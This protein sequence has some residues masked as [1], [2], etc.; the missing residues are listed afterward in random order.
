MFRLRVTPGRAL[1]ACA[2]LLTLATP[3]WAQEGARRLGDE[4]A[5]AAEAAAQPPPAPVLTRPPELVQFVEASYPEA[6]K[7][8]QREAA[9]QLILT[10]D[11]EGKVTDAVLQGEPVGDGFDEAAIEA[12]K[13]FVFRPA[14][15]DGKPAP[16]RIGFT[17]RF[18]FVPE[19][20]PPEEEAEAEPVA[21]LVGRVRE[22]GTGA[23]VPGA[24]V[25]V[26]AQGVE[27]LADAT[28]RFTLEG[29]EPGEIELIA[30]SPDHRREVVTLTLAEGE[31]V[32]VQ[33]RLERLRRSP[34]ETIVRGEREKT[35]LTRRTLDQKE[36]R[37]VPGTFG[38]PLRVVQNLPGL[39]R[40]PYILG[41]LL[42]R[43]TSPGDSAVMIDGHEVPL[44]YHFAGG[45]SVLPPEMLGR[46]D[47]FPGNFSV[48][49]GRAIGGIIDVETRVAWPK[50]WHGS[51]EIDLFD[52]GLYMEGPLTDDTSVS[53]SVRRSYIDTIL[54]FGEAV[55][56]APLATVLPVYYDY[57]A[58]VN[59]KLGG[60]DR[61]SLLVFGS[62]DDLTV[63]GDPGDQSGANADVDA[64]LGFHRLKLSWKAH[65]TD[66]VEWDL[67]PV[68]GVDF[69]GI[70]AGRVQADGTVVEFGLRHDLRIQA[71]DDVVVRTGLD[72]LGRYVILS[73][74]VPLRTSN[75]RPHPAAGF[76]SRPT[77]ELERSILLNGAAIYG[78]VEW[79][80][81]GGPVT[82]IPGVRTDY[83]RYFDQNRFFADPRVNA[84]WALTDAFTLKG[85]AG[86]FSQ[87]PP[88]W[89]LDEEFGNPDLDLE[90]AE[91]YGLGFEWK[92]TEALTLDVEGYWSRRHDLAERSDSVTVEGGDSGFASINPARFES[93]GT[94]QSYG[95][96]MLL[97]HE[98]TD[99]LY[100]WIS[101]T[102]AFTEADSGQ[103]G[104]QGGAGEAGGGGRLNQPHNMV[105]V[106][107]Y[108][109][110][111]NWET[112]LR[113]RLGSGNADTPV[114]GDTYDGD[115][116]FYRGLQGDDNTTRQP[117][118]HQ[119]DLRIERTWIFKAWELAAFLDLQNV[120]NA[121]NP[122][123]TTYDYRFRNSA[124]VRGLPVF[125][126]FGVRG[127][128]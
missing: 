59:H 117:L 83:Y 98:V 114:V 16:I 46:I 91:H 97:K 70:D 127:S 44:L 47:F 103:E 7:A 80:P 15:M 126:S 31:E 26:P 23:P 66:A 1:L 95:I 19:A 113:F 64:A 60:K 25:G 62:H 30:T 72:L 73:A 38:D 4:E 124:K 105:V 57:Q 50:E 12:A 121:E 28:G 11:A 68:V 40:T 3:A 100:G 119:L 35:S 29:V 88:E 56:D 32:D 81:G 14:E 79:A 54:R 21:R 49:Y 86:I 118:F 58:R 101:Y 89:R 53:A 34:F 45:P 107:S 13:Q 90:W 42:V 9:V 116:G 33:F 65:P 110:P 115:E 18:K 99:R 24:P 84:R 112:G 106:A 74:D 2:A 43:G 96:E 10:I 87:A 41:V 22:K 85:G 37:T 17:Y 94:G 122:E 39:A 104:G 67:S 76:G 69:T 6:A 92:L 51:A 20:P 5:E 93:T 71:A 63:V 77:D 78:E 8:T 82:L 125:P 52:A 55:S 109:W 120:Y 48:R 102:L 27:V 36:L 108:K 111:G 128:F 123:F 75:Y 61:L